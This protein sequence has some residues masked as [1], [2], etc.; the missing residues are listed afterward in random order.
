MLVVLLTFITPLS[1]EDSGHG[2]HEHGVGHLSVAVEGPLVMMELE[3]P[4]ASLAGFEH[5]PRNDAE[6]AAMRKT[7]DALEDG[8]ALFRFGPAGLR[9]RQHNVTVLSVLFENADEAGHADEDHADIFAVWEFECEGAGIGEIDAGGFFARFPGLERL[10]VQ[11]VSDRGQT[12]RELDAS[13]S[14][15]RF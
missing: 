3:G 5:R 12:A 13:A 6:Q 2:A 14:R 7:I 1:A 10:R 11:A 8:T 4:A 15:L 9:C